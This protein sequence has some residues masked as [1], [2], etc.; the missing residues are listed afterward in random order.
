[1]DVCLRVHLQGFSFYLTNF[2]FEFSIQEKA[3]K[4]IL[5]K[6]VSTS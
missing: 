1:M 4:S 6:K 5:K 2:L 3:E